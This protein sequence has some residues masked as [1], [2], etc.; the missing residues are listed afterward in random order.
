MEKLVFV[1]SEISLDGKKILDIG[2][3]KENG[4]EFHSNDLIKFS[5]FVNR[6]DYYVG[7]NI[8]LHDSKYI[9]KCFNTRGYKLID[10]LYM[11]PLLFPKKPYHRLV[12]D[13]KL[14]NFELNNPLS[15]SKKCRDL[16]YEEVNAFDSLDKSLKNIFGTL[17]SSDNRFSGF[18]DYVSWKRIL[19][20]KKE[21]KDRF[22]GLI[23]DNVDLSFIIQ[24]YPIEL[25]YALAIISIDNTSQGKESLTPAWILKQFPDTEYVM[26]LLRGT[27]CN[28]C[29]YCNDKF[30]ARKRLKD[31]FNYDNFRKF[32]NEDLQE[33][34]VKAAINKKSLLA[35]FPTGGGKSITFQLPA[36][37]SGETEKGLT[38]VISPLQSLMKDQVDN[39]ENKGISDA[40]TINGLLTAVERSEAIERVSS[41]IA[42]I[43]YIAP[44]SLRSKTIERLLLSR[45]ITRFVI[46]EAHCFSSWGQDFRVD[47]QYI[48]D[49][50]NRIQELKGTRQ[51]PVS[52]FTATAK[53]KVISDIC[54]YFKEKLGLSLELFSTSVQRSNLHY[55]VIPKNNDEEKYKELRNI[56]LDK[57]C[58]T[59]V[60][61][62]SVR[63]T[64]ELA[65]KLT[66][67]GIYALP[68]NGRMESKEKTENQNIFIADGCQVMVATNAF[69]M[70][71]DKD[72]IKLVIHYDISNSLENYVQESGR[73]GRD[74]SLDADCYILF[75]EE[76]L[77]KHFLQLNQTK[78]TMNEI[79]QV[80]QAIKKLTKTRNIIT[81]SAL[82]LAREAGWDDQI[83]DIET[84][85]RTA[86]NALENAKYVRRGQNS[87]RVFADSILAKT[88]IEADD[89]LVKSGLFKDEDYNDAKRILSSLIS[90]RSIAKSGNDDAES[91]VDYL[92][93]KLGIE[94]NRTISLIN[95]MRQANILSDDKDM[96]IS[97]LKTDTYSHLIKQFDGFASLERFLIDNVS[98]DNKKLDIKIMNEG[99][100]DS[101]IKISSV[102]NIKTILLYWTL[103]G[104]IE[105]SY[106]N[107]LNVQEFKPILT[108]EAI[109]SFIDKRVSIG[110]YIIEYLFNKRKNPEETTIEF[111]IFELMNAYNHRQNL[112]VDE[113]KC[114]MKDIED[115]LLYLSKIHLF[116]LEGGFLV[117]YSGMQIQKLIDNNSIRY[118]QENYK[119]LDDYYKLKVQQIHIVGE[120]ANM[121]VKD[122]N[123]AML[124][125]ED[126]FSLQYEGFIKKYFVGNRKGQIQKNITPKKY[127]LLFGNLSTK[128]KEI[129][130]DDNSKYISVIA[131]PGSGKTRVLVHKLA[132][133]L[134]LEDIKS[135]QLLMLT[136]SRM[137]ATEFKT[138]LIELIGNAAYYVDIKTFHSYCFDILGL[139]GKEENFDNVL[140]S[141]IDL[142]ESGEA[143][144]LKIAKSVLVIDEA[145]DMDEKE[146]KLIKT[147]ISRNE[148]MRVIAVGDDDQNIYEFRGSN[149]MYLNSFITELGAK[150]Y[151]MLENYRSVNK[152]VNFINV[153]E[154]SIQSRLKSN[155]LVGMRLDDGIVKI[156][157]HKSKYMEIPVVNEILK[158]NER[159]KK[160]AILTETN[161]QALRLLGLLNE[162]NINACLI[163]T[164]DEF[165]LYNLYEVRYF[166]S[167]F[168]KINTPVISTDVLDKSIIDLQTKFDRSPVIPTILNMINTYRKL[169]STYYKTDLIEL[170][171]ESNL[172][173]YEDLSNKKVIVSTIHKSKGREY[174][175]VYLVLNDRLSS[176]SKKR[177]LYVGASRAKN[178]LFIHTNNGCL[179]K[180]KNVKGVIYEKDNMEYDMPK[181]IRIDLSHRDVQLGYFEKKINAISKY[182]SSDKMTINEDYLVINDKKMVRFSKA[183]KETLDNINNQGYEV[184]DSY[185]RYLVYWKSDEMEEECLIILPTLMLRYNKENDKQ[186]N[187]KEDDKIVEND[188]TIINE[189]KE[190][191]NKNIEVKQ[192]NKNDNKV[193]SVT[194]VIEVV[195][196]RVPNINN[197]NEIIK[198]I[199]Y[200][201]RKLKYIDWVDNKYEITE[202][203]I[204][205]GL[206]KKKTENIRFPFLLNSVIFERIVDVLVEYFSLVS[207]EKKEEVPI[208]ITKEMKNKIRE[209][210][211]DYRRNKSIEEK[212][213]TF[214]IL[215][216]KTID[217][218]IDVMPRTITELEKVEGMYKTKID[219]YGK[220]IIEVINNTIKNME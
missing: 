44:E 15:D 144:S 174:D 194:N 57:N 2:A 147:I 104:Y 88:L 71:V 186:I 26:G 46:D 114:E 75:S 126:Y 156:T 21:I 40:V 128:Q 16:F 218:I 176:D 111:S 24:R 157:D 205:N 42:S 167:L 77:D 110:R 129:I 17:L 211:V 136:F 48:G 138:R 127:D 55:K 78:L 135:E 79:Q 199:N 92:S 72:N 6:C 146:Y 187:I 140:D 60:F 165:N 189:T 28:S 201:L 152:I 113:E 181:D 30:D 123:E 65:N 198:K 130:D 32:N 142:I 206:I 214:I 62:S 215:Y 27:S 22:F 217:S 117:L 14:L 139:V 132:S 153:F 56:I 90:K 177:R 195:N 208:I 207:N 18:F 115:T 188:L 66:K 145:Q 94:K 106:S 172:S 35:I 183:F 38:V 161:N 192:E 83:N 89:K 69:G 209:K 93:D 219:K 97:F 41:G 34:A 85:V 184:Y 158:N 148:E 107:I 5:N 190:L 51:I 125:V 74:L 98:F 59:I 197:N 63:E 168:D 164:N 160:I 43:L 39:L 105:K 61:V 193:Y 23:C 108:K 84:K 36:L 33:K 4:E 29:K 70:G 173:D 134:L 175:S 191:E 155:K 3:I 220:D 216:N 151:E 101:N 100:L 54:D 10:T 49:F 154:N 73:A 178:K 86:I 102:K 169:Y 64:T 50:I 150:R 99:A 171:K 45:N 58:P 31:F 7:H 162:N 96:S 20:I 163:Q 67:D 8:I 12:K 212:V 80:W 143:E 9:A 95:L 133:L 179:D 1:D 131:G 87:P 213:S 137:A 203:G 185:I 120:Y 119:S 180:Y 19:F 68:Y 210:I 53:Q 76:D 103:K 81:I 116:S 122:Y 202:L 118:K 47:Y 52:C 170:I 204:Q 13:D 112:F 141:A 109:T 25:S 196:N 182:S 91:R 200:N 124:F 82:E 37:I 159:D 149:S 166:I 121:M 11:S